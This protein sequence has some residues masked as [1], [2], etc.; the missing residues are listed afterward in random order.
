[1]LATDNCDLVIDMN[2]Y[3]VQATTVQ[4]PSDRRAPSGTPA[5]QNRPVRR[6]PKAQ[7]GPSAPS[8]TLVRLAALDRG[9][10]SGTPAQQEQP[11]QRAPSAQLGRSASSGNTGATGGIGARGPTGNTGATGGTG[12]QGAIGNIG[13]TGATGAPGAIGATGPIGPS[14]TPAQPAALDHRAAS[15]HKASSETPARQAELDHR[16]A[17]DR[18]ASSETPAQPEQ[19]APGCHRRNWAYRPNREHRCD[20]QHWTTGPYREH[21]RGRRSWTTGCIGPQGLIGNTG[22]TGPAGTSGIIA[23]SD[24]FALMPPDNPAT[25][26]VGTDVPFPQDGAISSGGAIARTSSSKFKLPPL[27]PTLP[28]NISSERG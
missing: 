20:G 5:Q 6:V 27:V 19:P 11:A 26:A 3:L 16:A 13:A 1:V 22:A 18:R 12:P 28:G 21:R 2:G 8:G 10:Q 25:V 24:F 14:G 15:D 17:L 9:A 7:L 4:G 23:F